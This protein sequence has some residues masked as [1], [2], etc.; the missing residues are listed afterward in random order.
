MCIRVGVAYVLAFVLSMVRICLKVFELCRKQDTLSLNSL[1]GVFGGCGDVHVGAC[2]GS[3]RGNFRGSQTEDGHGP[4]MF[5]CVVSVLCE[6][7]KEVARV[8]VSQTMNSAIKAWVNAAPGWY[9]P[10]EEGTSL[11]GTK[12]SNVLSSGLQVLNRELEQ[13]NNVLRTKRSEVQRIEEEV[14]LLMQV[15]CCHE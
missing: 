1:P 6:E 2:D 4:G 15:T 3:V 8:A 11:Y 7:N 9:G 12:F 5:S 13:A 14:A 10:S